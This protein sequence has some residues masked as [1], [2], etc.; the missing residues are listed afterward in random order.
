MKGFDEKGKVVS[1]RRF[2]GLYTTNVYKQWPEQIPLLRRK[3]AEVVE[4]AGYAADS[5]SGK[6][7]REALDAYPRDEL[8][9]I[10][11]EE[12]F[13]QSMAIL[14]LQDRER[15]R[16]LV[17]RDDFGRFVSCLVFLPRNRLTPELE[18]RIQSLL[19]RAFDGQHLEYAA[20]VGES[21]LARLHLVIY[22]EAAAEVT[23]E[24]DVAE[25][26][27][28]LT[29]AMRLWSDDLRDVLVEDLGEERGLRLHRSY[30]EAFPNSYMEDFSARAA[31]SDLKRILSLPD[32]QGFT[33]NLYRP[34]E[35]AENGF[36]LKLYQARDRMTLSSVLPLLE[37]MGLQVGEERPYEVTPRDGETAWIYDFG[38][39]SAQP[40]DF[41]SIEVRERF[42]E[43]FLQIWR[44]AVDNDAFN[45][46]VLGA[47]LPIRQVVVL[48]AYARYMRQAGTTFSFEHIAMTLANNPRLARTLMEMF[49]GRFDPDA[50]LSMEDRELAAKELAAD[51]ERGL[52]AV[53]NLNEDQV[54][55]RML[56]I[57]QA[58]VRT[59]FY[60]LDASGQPKPWLALKLDSALVPDCPLPRPMFETFVYSPRV[61]GVHMRMARVARGGLRWSDRL[62]DYR[63]EILGLM[64]AQSVKNAVIVPGGAKGGFV[65]KAPPS[66]GGFEALQAEAIAC[67]QIF[68]RALLDVADNLV[69]GEVAPP[70][71][72]VRHDA[73][74]PYLVVAADK[75]T[76]TFSDIANAISMEYGF[77][78][79]DA[80]A[81][82]GSSGYD[83]KAMG[84]TARGAFVS[85]RRHFRD[86]GVDVSRDPVTVVGIG[87]MSG[88]VFGNGMLLSKTLRLVAA[89]DHRDIFVDPSP[90]PAKALAERTRLFHLPRS[91]WQ[92]YSPELISPGGGVY[93]RSSKSVALSTE[94]RQ[95]LGLDEDAPELLRPDEVI[96]AILK[97]PVDLL[98]NGGIGTYVKSSEESN[99]EAGDKTNDIVRVNGSD[100]RCK[101]VGEGGNLG[102]TQRG[103]IEFALGGGRVNTDAIDN[104]AGVD[105]SDHEVNIKIL[106]GRAVADGVL[107]MRQRDELLVEMTDDVAEHVLEDNDSQTRAL[108][109]SVSQALSMLDVHARTLNALE[110]AGLNRAIEFLPSDEE[111][112]TRGAA[113]RGLTMPELAVV[114]AY[115][116]STIYAELLSSDLP[117]DPYFANCLELYFPAALRSRHLSELREHPLRREIISTVVTNSMINRGGTTF[118]WR[119][120]DETGCQA[121]DIAR[122]HFAAWEMFGMDGLWADI[123]ALDFVVPAST[124]V[125][126]VLEARKLVERAS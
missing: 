75:G 18:Q 54:L 38:L 98:W 97:A 12:L 83:H 24:V 102:F 17:R 123:E 82:G 96:R 4:R 3:V 1:E 23:G 122:A 10:T 65:L 7:L 21:V 80:F 63:T 52:D 73:D 70:A 114:L 46:L 101:V 25:L 119:L 95:V 61:E 90:D 93:S 62:E 39:R 100:L 66:A 113:G 92:D 2:L 112:R 20:R 5:H 109:N 49:R 22:T 79:G 27:T 51:F 6:A 9:Q 68:I 32:E 107:T 116:K 34:I 125:E 44:G 56:G 89:F 103:R 104:S 94:A 120:A 14:G 8:F 74:D 78:L 76:A 77:W 64:K 19:L 106:L 55:R 37:N 13:E 29:E 86:L 88:D 108:Y 124:Q 117:E 53:A 15:L 69:G 47:G 50:V 35:S 33:V 126:L 57:V 30:G 41:E 84:I 115:A 111:L 11:P 71:R 87:D 110:R 72:V 16:L 48:R 67:Y 45:R 58:T 40:A 81:S 105:T 85:V 43:A 28:L 31:A 26:E 60:Q 36:R 121:P 99:A 91:S 42:Q 59:N 118:A